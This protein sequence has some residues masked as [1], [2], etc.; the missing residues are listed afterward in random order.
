MQRIGNR[1]LNI[2]LTASAVIIIG[3]I[4]HYYFSY[5]SVATAGETAS[6]GVPVLPANHPDISQIK[7]LRFPEEGKYCL[8]CHQGIEPTRPWTRK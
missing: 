7:D 4:I 3:F 5:W 8:A 1:L 2:A 6:N